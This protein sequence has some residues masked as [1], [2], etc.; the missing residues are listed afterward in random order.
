MNKKQVKEFSKEFK[1]L[2]SQIQSLLIKYGAG[3]GSFYVTAIGIKDIDFDEEDQDETLSSLLNSHEEDESK[4]DVFYGTNVSDCDELEEILD[5]VY[6]AHSSEMDKER[7]TR[8]LKNTPPEK[9]TTT[10][11]DWINLN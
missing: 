1:S 4:I 6:Y 9:G 3:P 10:A 7:K 11:Q 2:N 8:I 5:N